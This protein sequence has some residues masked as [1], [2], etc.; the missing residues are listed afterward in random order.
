[1]HGMRRGPFDWIGFALGMLV[2]ALMGGA[3]AAV[4]HL[5]K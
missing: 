1:M 3:L 2:L 4:V 5:V